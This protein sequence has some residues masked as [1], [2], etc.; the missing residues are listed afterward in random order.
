MHV[1]QQDGPISKSSC[2]WL[3]LESVRDLPPAK[4]EEIKLGKLHNAGEQSL[5]V[6]PF[7]G[8]VEEVCGSVGGLSSEDFGWC[9][10]DYAVGFIMVGLGWEIHTWCGVGGWDKPML[11]GFM[12]GFVCFQYGVCF[13]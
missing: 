11:F 7:S 6:G 12:V 10:L 5:G 4:P 9:Y 3:A 13:L 2:S 8:M 1:T